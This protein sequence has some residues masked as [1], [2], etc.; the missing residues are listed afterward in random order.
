MIDKQELKNEQNKIDK[1][2]KDDYDVFD[3]NAYEHS[4]GDLT[5]KQN[6]KFEDLN[7]HQKRKEF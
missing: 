7:F 4:L 2:I 6:K 1:T 3:Q 5:E